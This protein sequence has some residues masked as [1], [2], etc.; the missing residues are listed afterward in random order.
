MESIFNKLG[1]YDFMGIWGPG[2]IFCVYSSFTFSS[3]VDEMFQKVNMSDFWRGILFYIGI[4]Y[5]A[6]VIFHEIGKWAVDKIT[7]F[8]DF[9]KYFNISTLKLNAK[10]NVWWFTPRALQYRYK[11]VLEDCDALPTEKFDK[12]YSELKYTNG[13]NCQRL[14]TYHAVYGLSRGL[15]VAIVLHMVFSLISLI[16][17]ATSNIDNTTW[18]YIVAD[19]MLIY[20]LF[21]RT[22][23]Y[24]INWI[25]NV[26]IQYHIAVQNGMINGERK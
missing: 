1:I 8:F 15:C 23:R 4:A 12:A 24:Y 5:L 14:N 20:F 22:V 16:P 10:K 6:G 7:Y 9:D 3:F 2:V 25:M 26:Y 21:C 18:Y 19:L 13:I 11:K 17:N